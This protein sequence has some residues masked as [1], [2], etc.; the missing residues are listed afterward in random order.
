MPQVL[1]TVFHFG[2]ES[3]HGAVRQKPRRS[4]KGRFKILLR[5]KMAELFQRQ[6]R[7]ETAEGVF[8]VFIAK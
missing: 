3:L 6:L 7:G 4:E 1:R 2:Q 8:V 5:L